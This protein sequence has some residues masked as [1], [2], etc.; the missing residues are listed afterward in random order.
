MAASSTPPGIPALSLVAKALLA[1]WALEHPTAAPSAAAMALALAWSLG[2]GAWTSYL[3]GTNNFGSIHAT[4]GF[5]NA[6]DQTAGFGMVAFLDHGAAGAYITRFAVYP[7]LLAGASAFLSLVERDVNLATVKTPTDFATGF[8]VH[9]Y[10]E[11]FQTPVTPVAQRAAALAAGTLT[12]A[13]QANIAAGAA[14]VSAHLSAAQAAVAAAPSDPGN[15]SAASVG[16]PFDTLANRL[17]PSSAYAPHTIAHAQA[18]L[19]NN[20][21]DPPAGAI[22]LADALASPTGDGVWLFGPGYPQAPSTAAAAASSPLATNVVGLVVGAA[23]ATVT[24]LVVSSVW[25]ST[26]GR[27][28]EVLELLEEDGVTPAVKVYL[29]VVA[30][31]AAVAGVVAIAKSS[32]ASSPAAAPPAPA[33]APTPGVPPQGSTVWVRATTINPGQTVRIG[34]APA[35]IALLAQSTTGLSPNLT[36][37]ESLLANPA[38]VKVLG[39]TNF[40]AWGPSAPGS[41][42][43]SGAPALPADWPPDDTMAASEFHAQF[44][45]AENATAAAPFPPLPVSSLPISVL[46]WVPKGTGA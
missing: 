9:G 10:Y 4:V 22:S 40:Q 32:S 30:A 20:A 11:G 43:S 25:G 28:D 31:A 27:D 17:T 29:G 42:A 21:I 39:A 3:L 8:Y 44:V 19:G 6:N 1:A 36:G 35:A 45:Y 18:L 13:D 16:P 23:I 15:P 24:G 37:F 14:L 38:L 7:S 12:A 41:A 34:M 33:P 26:Q 2:E 46:A 5:A